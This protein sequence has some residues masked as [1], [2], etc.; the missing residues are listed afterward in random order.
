MGTVAEIVPREQ[1]MIYEQVLKEAAGRGIPFAL[2]GAF[3]VGAY[4]G[5]WRNTKDLDLAILPRDREAMI[6]V[7]LEAGL[8]DYYDEAPYDRGWIFRASREGAIV[9][10]IWAMANRRAYFDEGFIA[11]APYAEFMGM[12]V[13]VTPP[14]E[15]IWDKIYI[16]QRQ[17]S[18]WPDALNV[19]HAMAAKLDWDH[20]L[21]RMG[22]DEWLLAGLLATYRWLCPGRA[23]KIPARVWERLHM[24][25]PVPGDAPGVDVRR[26]NFF[27]TRPWFNGVGS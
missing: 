16:M 20:L 9:D 17:R 10:V 18:D 21:H 7:L 12:P 8:Q 26:V 1:A 15:L 5:N 23:H 22:E 24:P 14:E 4:T 2:C 3:A 25:A 6:G 27:D 13:L 19:V 11:R